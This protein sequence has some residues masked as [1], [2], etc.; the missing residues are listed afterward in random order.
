MSHERL[1]LSLT[2]TDQTEHGDSNGGVR[3]KTE[4]AEVVFNPIG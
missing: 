3:E 4:R 1:C 2:D